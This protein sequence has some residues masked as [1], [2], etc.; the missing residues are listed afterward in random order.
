MIYIYGG[1]NIAADLYMYALRAIRNAGR[2]RLSSANHNEFIRA[3]GIIHKY[4]LMNWREASRCRV[5]TD[6]NLIV[7]MY[8]ENSRVDAA[9][10]AVYLD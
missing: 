5:Q 6:E 10:A 1:N 2:A 7:F 9:A 8:E 3:T 4:P